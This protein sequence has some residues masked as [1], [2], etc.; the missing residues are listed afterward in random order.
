MDPRVFLMPSCLAL[1]ESRG[2]CCILDYS[3]WTSVANK[4]IGI[5]TSAQFFLIGL[6]VGLAYYGLLPYLPIEE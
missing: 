6:L 1:V 5:S 3:D 4:P 2:I